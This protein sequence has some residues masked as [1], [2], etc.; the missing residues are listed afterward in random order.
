MQ[1]GCPGHPDKTCA[2]DCPV[3]LSPQESNVGLAGCEPTPL[4]VPSFSQFLFQKRQSAFIL[5]HTLKDLEAPV[6]F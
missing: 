6:A 5:R 1:C 3:L 2:E 4:D